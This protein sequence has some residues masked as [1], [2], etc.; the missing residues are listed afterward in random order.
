MKRIIVA[1]L[2]CMMALAAMP[3][4]AGIGMMPESAVNM[5]NAAYAGSEGDTIT[6]KF[7]YDEKYS[8]YFG[9]VKTASLLDI[10]NACKNEPQEKET[11][12]E[13]VDAA[14][15]TE[16]AVTDFLGTLVDADDYSVAL[17]Y[18]DSANETIVLMTWNGTVVYDYVNDINDVDKYIK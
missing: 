5:L 3:A 7:S 15:G 16:T 13:L 10:A 17:F 14:K 18:K 6:Y 12:N 2:V 4:Y 8:T 11:W 1:T 9:I